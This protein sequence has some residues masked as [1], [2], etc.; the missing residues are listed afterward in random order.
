MSGNLKIIGVIPARLESQRLPQKVLRRI[1]GRPML[2]WVY[3]RAAGS[4][5]LAQLVVASDS[6]K[7]LDYC[8]EYGIPHIRT[9]QHP[10]GSDRL[11]EVMENTDGDVYVNIQGDEPTVRADHV[12]CLVKPIIESRGEITTLKFAIDEASAQD[13][14]C[15][16]VVTDLHG[17]ALYFS[18]LPVPYNREDRKDLKYYKH[19]GLYGFTRAA[20]SLFH[21]LRPSYLENAEK[22]EQLRLLENGVPVLVEETPHDTIGVD[23]EEDLERAAAFLSAEKADK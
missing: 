10:S 1:H 21:S 13:P 12:E 18:R 8:R 19:L 22:L 15:V 17:R 5:L 9:G 20:L 4:S 7:V 14:N 3:E 2:H 16:K 23:T 6:E 11:H